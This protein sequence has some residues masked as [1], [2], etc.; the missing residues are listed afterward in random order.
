[1]KKTKQLISIISTAILISM[2]AST[3]TI[4]GAYITNLN[5]DEGTTW[6][7]G[8][9][10]YM[11]AS[12]SA[13]T[14]AAKYGNLLNPDYEWWS[15]L[16][17]TGARTNFNPG[18]APDRPDI[19]WSSDTIPDF[20]APYSG[21]VAFAGKVFGQVNIRL[22]NNTLRQHLAAFDPFTGQPIWQTPLPVGI[23]FA[24]FGCTFIHRVDDG[25]IMVRTNTGLAMFRVSDGAFLWEDTTITPNAAYHRM[26]Y[27]AD[28]MFLFGPIS[29][30][31]QNDEGFSRY[32]NTAWDL[33][34]P[35][36]DKGNGGR[37]AWE[38]PNL[39]NGRTQ[40]AVGDGKLFL[41]S[42]VSASL[43]CLNAA[44]GELIWETKRFD[45]AGYSGTYIEGKLIV[46]CQS[47]HV[48]CYDANTGEL[49]W[50]NDMG[51]SNRA[52]NVWN[53]ASAYGRVYVHDLGFEDT[54][55]TR[56]LDLE[57]GQEL[58][59]ARTDMNIG[60]YV[61]IVAD[62]KV[63]ARQSDGSATTGRERTELRFS[64]WDAYTGEE[65]WG[66]QSSIAHPMIAYGVLYG[67]ANNVLYAYST[68]VAPKDYPMWRGNVEMPGV[69]GS[70]GPL[71]LFDGP[72]WTYTTGGA[73]TCQPV[74][75]N[76][77]L[78]F[79]SADRYV[80]CI[81]AYNGNFIWKF[82]TQE[83]R[84]RDFGSSPAVVGN[85][86]IIGPDDGYI[87]ALDANTGLK[88]WQID[89]GP[90]QS[91]EIGS[92]QAPT[93]SS[94]II[95]NSRIYVSSAHNNKTYCLD[96]N[97]NVLW[98]Y[99]TGTPV[100]GS[101]TIANNMIYFLES[102]G[103]A[104][105]VSASEGYTGS[106]HKLNMNGQKILEFEIRTD[107]RSGTY[108]SPY[109]SYQTPAVVGDYVYIGVNSRDAMAYNGTS[110]EM[111]FHTTQMNIAAERSQ[112]SPVVVPDS[113]L[114][115]QNSTSGEYTSSAGN[116]V[117]CGAGP[118]MSCF[119]GD[120]GTQLWS[121]WGGWEI[122]GS[123]VF[124]G[125]YYSAVLYCG[126]E[127]YGM[128]CW[129]ASNGTPI[130]WYTTKGGLSGSPAVWDGKLYFGSQDNNI[131]CFE[132]HP[133]QNM[134]VSISVDKSQLSN[135]NQAVTVTAQLVGAPNPE[136]QWPYP[137]YIN[138][139]S[140]QGMPP[141]PDAKVLVTFTN[142]DGVET[143]LTATTDDSGMAS[144]TFTPNK[145]GN[146]KAMT[147]FEGEDKTTWTYGYAFSDQLSI[148]VGEPQSP[149]NGDNNEP[150][151]EGIPMEYIYA[152][153]GIIAV[154]VIA[155][156]AYMYLKK[157]K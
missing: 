7:A 17:N 70:A 136:S 22:S 124:S 14:A 42:Y 137:P 29:I 56:C 143:T 118:T 139:H 46:A 89:T 141:L 45:A 147:W 79:N 28:L 102:A 155:I 62:G 156:V 12:N 108:D 71:N 16:G 48:M 101:V 78:Y 109:P 37:V 122:F 134:A 55:G 9:A 148:S 53:V 98:D 57:T 142:P 66:I 38:V 61:I 99:T 111:I 67:V 21:N 49:L 60:Y 90:Y 77:K 80:Y 153:I 125:H 121:A 68:A 154:V 69:T 145:E 39:T 44:T 47:Q 35:E 100:F 41:G 10:G 18:P 149:S 95:H 51:R 81:D 104:R 76:G 144:W 132:D 32:M 113:F 25:H 43:Y 130:S 107:W 146:W 72:K 129:N 105:I 115:A 85:K 110:G 128:T 126:S 120:N 127:S 87:Y 117:F 34:D 20:G 2:I 75:A 138:P 24:Q 157:R 15:H 123:P 19:L 31:S 116:F 112:A 82:Q 36:V 131:Y 103:A 106:L 26:V 74:I 152:I 1:M 4:A 83:P 40:Q 73:V 119:R 93:S 86:V 30:V 65:I 135:T 3:L 33:S 50:D 5:P 64:C 58:W 114:R 8:D 91:F 54:G 27:D 94:P 52:F 97:G 23:T 150:T 92:G 88:L 59:K 96:L 133:S 84:M 13:D 140:Y 63:Y 6:L 151:D 11:D